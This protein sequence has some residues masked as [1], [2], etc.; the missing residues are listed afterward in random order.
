MKNLYIIFAIGFLITM[1]CKK[2]EFDVTNLNK[3]IVDG[4]IFANQNPKIH[5]TL[6]IGYGDDA[7]AQTTIDNA[8][9]SME[10]AGVKYVLTS[11]GNGDYIN[12]KVKIKAGQELNLSILYAGYTVTASTI[13]PSK[14]KNFQSS[15]TQ[16][17]VIAQQ[18]GPGMGGP[19]GGF[20]Q[21]PAAVIS[22]D[23]DIQEYYT[24]LTTNTETSPEAIV[25]GGGGRGGDM[26]IPLAQRLSQP[27]QTN[28]QSLNQRQ[29]SFYGNHNLIL[30]KVNAEYTNLYNNRGQSSLNLT[31]PP[32]NITN[33]FG[34]FTAMN[35]DTL[36][37][38]VLK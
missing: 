5:L 3:P 21:T 20:N 31:N 32:T 24:L 26:N 34:I 16:I 28:T 33:G 12:D 17:Q 23:N 38:Q 8:Q 13:V 35:A 4:I 37:V 6:P 22:W 7:T 14:P 18:G 30:F 27:T 25:N 2:V 1:G 15:A 36:K 29:F 9:V 19:G 11:K 10:I